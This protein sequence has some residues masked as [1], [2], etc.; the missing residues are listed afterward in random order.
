MNRIGRGLLTYSGKKDDFN[1][2]QKI[3]S[4]DDNTDFDLLYVKGINRHSVNGF[5]EDMVYEFY[6]RAGNIVGCYSCD[7]SEV[8]KYMRDNIRL[9]GF[10]SCLACQMSLNLI[11]CHFIASGE[12]DRVF[13]CNPRFPHSLYRIPV[14]LYFEDAMFREWQY[15]IMDYSICSL[16]VNQRCIRDTSIDI[17]PFLIKDEKRM[18]EFCQGIVDSGMLD[19]LSMEE[20]YT[21]PF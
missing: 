10:T 8:G 19:R 18:K 15:P 5:P 20:A 17:D 21:I 2:I 14:S 6:R 4:M 11:L 3:V 13:Y 16:G 12:Y 7:G 1:R 9:F